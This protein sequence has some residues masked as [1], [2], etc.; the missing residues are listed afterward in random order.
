M[1]VFEVLGDH[2]T[3]VTVTEGDEAIQAF[4]LDGPYET[5][6]VRVGMSRQLH[7]RRAVRRKSFELPIPSIRCVA[8][9]SS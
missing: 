1:T 8:G 5:L 7:R 9:R 6:G 4:I 3:E 2:E